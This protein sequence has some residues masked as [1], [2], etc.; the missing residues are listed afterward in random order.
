MSSTENSERFLELF[1][2]YQDD[3]KRYI[4]S[5][6]PHRNETDDLLQNTA[7]ALMKKFDSYDSS[8]PFLNWAFRFAYFEVLKFREK[9]AKRMQFCKATLELLAEE[10]VEDKSF[11]HARTNALER[12]IEKIKPEWQVLLEMRYGDGMKIKDIAEKLN[13]PIKKCYK[14]FEMIRHKLSQCG[15][16]RLNEE[17]WGHS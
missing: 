12:C 15:Q 4:I 16:L 13:M 11:A 2:L 9:Y 8:L 7:L 6:H 14:Q 5:I 1:V 3:L 17:G 10:S